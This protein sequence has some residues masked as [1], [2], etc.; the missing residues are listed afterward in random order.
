MYGESPIVNKTMVNYDACGLFAICY[1]AVLTPFQLAF[2]P[3]YAS[4][5]VASYSPL[6]YIDRIIDLY[7][8]FDTALNFIRPTRDAS[9]GADITD[10]RE[11]SFNYVTG[12]FCVDVLSSIPMDLISLFLPGFPRDLKALR[13]L[14]FFRLVKLFRMLRAARLITNWQDRFQISYSTVELIK[15]LGIMILSSHWLACLWGLTASVTPV[16]FESWYYLVTLDGQ[17][18]RMIDSPYGLY[19]LSLYFSVMTLCTVGYGDIH[20][21]TFAEHIVCIIMMLVG[22]IVWAYLIGCLTAIVSNLDRHGNRFKQ[23]ATTSWSVCTCVAGLYVLVLLRICD[24]LCIDRSWTIS[25][26]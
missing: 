11:I 25:T 22:G 6:F 12:W 10:I 14:R 18:H 19:V 23:V 4:V 16:E 17:N 21:I 15:I 24:V 5:Q 2:I 13:L 1:T 3:A 7:F 26:L 20:P 9:R 8:L